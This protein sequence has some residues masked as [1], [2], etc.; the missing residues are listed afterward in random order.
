MVSIDEFLEGLTASGLMTVEEVHALQVSLPP[1]DGPISV[2]ALATELV[3]RGRLTKYQV[4]RIASGRSAGLVLGKYVIQDKIGEGGMG[5]V[6][7]AE[8]RRMKRPVVVKVLPETAMSSAGS[9][10]R[11]Q[12]EV[13]AAAQLSHP[14]IVT[15]FDADEENGVHF[16]VME[17]VE[18]ESLGELATRQGPL[19]MD[20]ALS[21]ALQAAIGLEYAHATGI[22]HRDIKPN[23][24][25][26]DKTGAVKILD[27]GLARFEDE[28]STLPMGDDGLTKQNHIIGTV[29]YMS[30]EQVD[31]SA[32]VDRRSDI[33]SLGCTLYRL[34][35]GTPPFQGETLVKTL[36]AHRTD[37][38]PSIR[39]ARPDAPEWLEEVFRRMLAKRPEDRYQSMS[40]LISD[41]ETH[42]ESM[43][44]VVPRSQLSQMPKVASKEPDTKT[45]DTPQT[46]RLEKPSDVATLAKEAAEALATPP[47][48]SAPAIGIDLGTT[49]SAIAHLDNAGRPQILSNQEGDKTTPSV[50]LIEDGNVVVGKE[51]AKAMATDMEFIAECAK[52]DLGMEVFHHTIGGVD[53]PPEVI[54][55]W[56]LKKV[57]LDAQRQIGEF[58]KAVVTVPAYFDEVRRKATQDAGYI[59]GIDVIDIINEPTAAALAFGFQHG[60]LYPGASLDKPKRVL[61]YDLGGGTFDVTI[62]EIADGEFVTLATDGDVQLGGRDWDQRLVDYIAEQFIRKHGIDPRE[63]PNTLG[64]LLR[65]CEDAKRTLSTRTKASVACDFQGRAERFEVTRQFF[66]EI[67]QDLLERTAFTTRHTLQATGLSWEDID[68]VLTVG[69]STRMPAV[70]GM[71]TMLAGQVPDD[72]LSP[73]EAV[74]QGA[75]IHAGFVLDRLEGRRPQARVRNVNSHSLGIVGTDAKTKRKQTAVLIPRNTPLPAKAKRVFTT[76]KEGQRSV[77]ANIVEGESR[78]P[79]ACMPIGR[80]TVRNLPRD[81]PAGTPIEVRFQYED[82]GRLRIAVTIAG[83][84]GQATHEITRVHNLTQNDLSAWRARVAGF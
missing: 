10:E 77:V 8:H 56:I 7:V 60:R 68:H 41:L 13:E 18:G 74:A 62:M 45:L 52:R 81:L 21:C 73:D 46:L 40:E 5:E 19:A 31:D 54:Q 35:T 61:V 16:L 33:Y 36:L 26:I 69:G 22:I 48:R 30:P 38:I 63:D 25:L 65:E 72:T 2:K 39:A 15:A 37:P 34:L 44:V 71:L 78:D 11:F 70:I 27:M 67:T 66:E 12:R 42:L 6:F 49:F 14:N 51:A 82:N 84:D 50:V 29:E 43:G 20:L 57:R 1:T 32:N 4:G 75:A 83:V 53:Y 23:N 76:M 80:C 17:H 24:L 58:S 79:S 64:R 28:R 9:V 55:A 59:A 47:Q 3:R